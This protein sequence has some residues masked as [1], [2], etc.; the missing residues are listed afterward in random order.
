MAIEADKYRAYANHLIRNPDDPQTLVNQFA[1]LSEKRENAAHYY[2]L[3]KRAY[4]IAPNEINTVFNYGSACHRTGRFKESLRLYQRCV[5]LADDEWMPKALHHVGIAYR[6]LNKN[7]EAIEFYQKAY[8]LNGRP[9]CLKDKALA[10]LADGQL[11][12]GL[13]EFEIRREVAIQKLI[14]NG[15]N[16]V[17][18]QKL[19]KHVIHWQGEDLTGKSVVVYHEEGSGDFIQFCRFLPMLRKQGVKEIKLTGPLPDLLDLVSDNFEID[20]IVPLAHFECDYVIGSMTLPWRCGVDWKDVNGK[21]Y[22][23]AEPAKLPRRGALNVGL[24]WQGNPSY[25]MNV[26]RSMKFMDFAPLFD[27]P[28]V[29]FHSLQVGPPGLD[30]TTAGFDGFVANLEPFMPNWRGTARV[31]QAL[32]VIVT[33]DTACAHLAGAL[34]KPVLTLVTNSC[35]WRWDRNSDRSVWYDSMRVIRQQKQDEWAPCVLDVKERLKKM[36]ADGRRQAA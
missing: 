25:G 28:G 29:A 23:K 19:P 2:Y 36:V 4:E 10:M 34:G 11:Y 21:P 26:H 35:D 9:E 7:K 1:V 32:D 15:G 30:V 24:V 27:I 3:A 20:G 31:M 16:L 5:E 6:T 17:T 18:Q 14:E 33:V 8:D 13:K 12:A 22:F